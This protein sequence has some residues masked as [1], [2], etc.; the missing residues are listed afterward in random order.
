MDKKLL[1]RI[2]KGLINYEKSIEETD[3]YY[4]ELKRFGRYPVGAP[5]GLKHFI[6]FWIHLLEEEGFNCEGFQ[7]EYERITKKLTALEQKRGWDY[8]EKLFSDLEDDI[9][10]YPGVID[11]FADLEPFELEIPNSLS[12]R[13]SIEIYLMELERDYDLIDIKRKVSILDEALKCIYI[14]EVN[15]VLKYYPEVEDLYLPDRF[16]WEHPSKMLKEKQ[17][18]LNNP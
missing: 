7:K 13:T 11:S 18:M 17:A 2:T 1:N 12:T 9:G 4:D 6:P 3:E 15:K 8:R 10:C 16:W 14:R 5:Y